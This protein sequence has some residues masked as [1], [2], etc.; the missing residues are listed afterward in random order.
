MNE[1]ILSGTGHRPKTLGLDYSEKSNKLLRTFIKE[2][3]LLITDFSVKEA[4]SGGATGFD[5]ALAEACVGLGIPVRLALPFLEFGSNWPKPGQDRL[6]AIMKCSKIV[7]TSDQ[8]YYTPNQYI[9]R[10]KYMVDNS[11]VILA[12]YSGLDKSG[13]GATVR[14]AKEKERQIINIWENW[15]RFKEIN[16]DRNA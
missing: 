4:I 7:Y 2:Q 5:I 14:Y 8:K 16:I 6:A 13:T 10:D 15:L 1:V 12:L 11:Q 9:I 3:I